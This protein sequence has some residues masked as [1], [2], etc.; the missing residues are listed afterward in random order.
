MKKMISILLCVVFV[1]SMLTSC[2]D[3]KVI[4]GTEYETYGLFNSDELKDPCVKY[5]FV[6]GNLIWG[7]ILVETVIAPI[8]FFGFSIYEPV[9][10][11]PNCKTIPIK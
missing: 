4:D 3:N 8:Y 1:V 5:E 6:W 10:K 2:A 9:E 11:K 7:A